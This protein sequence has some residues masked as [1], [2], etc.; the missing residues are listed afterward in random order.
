MSGLI[1]HLNVF[2]TDPGTYVDPEDWSSHRTQF[3]AAVP[4][5]GSVALTWPVQAVNSGRLV[6][7]VAVTDVQQHRVTV[8]MPLELTVSKRQTVDPG[9]V[10]PLAV[11]VPG[12][13]AVVL[14]L[15]LLRR[16]RTA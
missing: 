8:S 3:P 1:A 12:A 15:V 5:H 6:V 13:V 2:S 11:G 16:R 7:Y 9:G 10:L 14:G 4:A